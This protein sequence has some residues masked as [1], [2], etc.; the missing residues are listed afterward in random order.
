MKKYLLYITLIALAVLSCRKEESGIVSGAEA[1]VPASAWTGYSWQD[2]DAIG[3]YTSDG[4][5]NAK[6]VLNAEG[7]F[8]GNFGD[9]SLIEGA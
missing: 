2:G 3:I 8:T 6:A 4:V 9:A 5:V 1:T 7:T